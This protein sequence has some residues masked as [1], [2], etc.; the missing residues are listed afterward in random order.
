MPLA[1]TPHVYAMHGS[2]PFMHCNEEETCQ[3]SKTFYP[4]PKLSEIP[5][6]A[7]HVPKCEACGGNMKPHGMFFDEMYSEHYY[8][9]DTIT[10]YCDDADALIVIGTTLETSFA[11]NIVIKMT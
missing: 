3:D 2:I 7:N 1:F 6:K 8:R 11:R 4:V 10:N 9:Y 5:D